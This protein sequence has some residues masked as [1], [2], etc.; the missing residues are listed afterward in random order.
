MKAIIAYSAKER[1]EIW[2]SKCSRSERSHTDSAR[3]AVKVGD[4]SFAAI[5]IRISCRKWALRF[6]GSMGN[7]ICI[8]SGDECRKN[9]ILWLR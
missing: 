6:G 1:S 8:S 5:V 4:T 3:E 2:G 7:W 9:I